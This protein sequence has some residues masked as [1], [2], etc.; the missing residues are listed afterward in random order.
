MST[1][2]N[3][4]EETREILD[5]DITTGT[6]IVRLPKTS[7]LW[8]PFEHALQHGMDKAAGGRFVVKPRIYQSPVSPAA[9]ILPDL[10]SPANRKDDWV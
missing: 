5:E 7:T 1:H 2:F 8:D 3:Y 10:T 6:G 4:I 9:H